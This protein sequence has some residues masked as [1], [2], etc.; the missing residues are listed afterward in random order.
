MKFI[1][2][3]SLLLLNTSIFASQDMYVFK[4]QQQTEQ[5]QQ[6]TQQIRCVVCQNQN[7]ADSNAPLA[8]DLRNKIYQMINAQ[9]SNQEIQQFLVKRYGEFILLKPAFNP[10]TFALWTFP[11]FALFIIGFILFRFI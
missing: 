5:F 4:S 9:Q 11:F 8:K 10:K 1:F 6:L 2:F 7:L 3:I